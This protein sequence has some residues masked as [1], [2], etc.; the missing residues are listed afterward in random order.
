MNSLFNFLLHYY[1]VASLFAMPGLILLLIIV[2]LKLSRYY[3]Y[4]QL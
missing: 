4:H 3:M 2:P 1:V